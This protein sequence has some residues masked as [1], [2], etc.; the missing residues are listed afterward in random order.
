M[1]D[2]VAIDDDPRMLSLLPY[3]ILRR[4]KVSVSK[5]AYRNGKKFL[6]RTRVIPQRRSA[7][8]A[9]M[10]AALIAAVADMFISIVR[11]ADRH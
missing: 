4:G 7:G 3:R 6:M 8:R 11:A 5:I 10:K 1:F 9:E 2:I